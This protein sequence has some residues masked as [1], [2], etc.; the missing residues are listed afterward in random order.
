MNM[1]EKPHGRFLKTAVLVTFFVLFAY[2]LKNFNIFDTESLLKDLHVMGDTRLVKLLFVGI[3]T[4]L[5]VFFVPVSTVAATAGL[6]FEL[7]GILLI[8]VSGLLSALVSYGLAKIF[9]SDATRWVE[10]LYRRKEREI[11][12]EELYE[13]IKEHGF[14]YAL[15]VRALPFMPF[16]VGN[17]LFGVSSVTLWDYMTTTFITVTIGQ[18]ITVF[19]VSMAADFMAQKTGT[20]IGLLLKGLYYFGI[21]YIMRK[22]TRTEEKEELPL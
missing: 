16:Q 22:N 20:V 12:L 6:L 19:L 4:V 2:L 9:K 21:Y 18:G 7:D 10:K 3:A 5:L 14:S 13:K 8:T 17:L 1:Q 15:F 11:P